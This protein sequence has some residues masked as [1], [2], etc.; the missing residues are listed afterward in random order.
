VVIIDLFTIGSEE[1]FLEVFAREVLKK[2]SSRWEDWVG[3]AKNYFKQLM[4]KVSVGV[5]PT[6]DFSIGFD[7]KEL[8]KY[9]DEVLNLPEVIAK[10]K[11]IQFVICIDE[12]QN[13][14]N[15][16]TFESFEK[17]MRAVWQRQKQVTY[18]LYGSNRHMME[19]IFNHSSKPFYRFGDF[20]YLPKIKREK[21]ISFILESFTNTG[22]KIT[23][24]QAAFI[25][26]KMNCHSWYVQQFSHYVWVKTSD[27][28]TETILQDAMRELIDVN[29]PFFQAQVESLSTTQLNLLKAVASGEKQITSVRAMQDFKLGTSNN[30]IKNREILIKKDILQLSQANFEWLDP[31]FLIWFLRLF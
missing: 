14:S 9:S 20:M 25:T 26:D 30:I 8:K 16:N 21:W 12:F 3:H 1:E 22:K 5:D 18:C 27:E 29:T 19:E 23:E 7:W 11:G 13:L 4:P 28:V 31:V 24:E 10:E 6:T 15:Y 2:S 17:K